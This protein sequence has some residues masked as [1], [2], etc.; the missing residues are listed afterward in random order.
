MTDTIT[1]TESVETILISE[2]S[3]TIVIGTSGPQG[4]VGPAGLDGANGTNGVNGTN[5]A[6]GVG[7][8]VGGT[9][10][11]VLTKNSATDYDTGWATPATGGGG[12][13]GASAPTPSSGMW[14]P[15]KHAAQ[16]AT[17]SSNFDVIFVRA[18]NFTVPVAV[19]ITELMIHVT[20]PA[21]IN[22]QLVIYEVDP[23]KMSPTGLPLAHAAL[24]SAAASGTL[25]AALNTPVALDPTKTY[26]MGYA[27]DVT[28]SPQTVGF[29]NYDISTVSDLGVPDSGLAYVAGPTVF[30]VKQANIG[31]AGILTTDA[32]TFNWSLAGQFAPF[33]WWKA[34]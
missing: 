32:G 9:T 25:I 7:V 11:Q 1:I 24:I 26:A 28:G 4:A 27:A 30:T 18:I 14:Y 34:Q 15:C 5:G 22:I 13:G 3:E 6:P 31:Y 8:P 10:G 20:S 12:T 17:Q 19:T 33:F 21:S 29:N 2:E 23:V 16:L